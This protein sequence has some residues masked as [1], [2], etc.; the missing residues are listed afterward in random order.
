MKHPQE[1]VELRQVEEEEKVEEEKVVEVVPP[2]RKRKEEELVEEEEL[3]VEEEVV[4][5]EEE[6]KV[7]EEKEVEVVPPW[8]KKR[9]RTPPRSRVVEV[10]PP[11]YKKLRPRTP[12]RSRV[13]EVDPKWREMPRTSSSAAAEEV[14]EEEE[15][16][17]WLWENLL[18]GQ[19]RVSPG[20]PS[21]SISWKAK[22][23]YAS[24]AAKLEETKGA[25]LDERKKIF[26][27]LQ[28]DLHPDKNPEEPGA[29]NIAFQMLM[30]EKMM[31]LA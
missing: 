17:D 12:P 27:V 22:R 23:D 9:P 7:E 25:P 13:A 8:Y 30:D 15:G 26:R 4:E 29:A 3:E 5:E 14:E 2:W 10:V 24:V 11:W 21:A 1:E 20:R 31:Y 6:E 28:R 18:E 19:A 16:E